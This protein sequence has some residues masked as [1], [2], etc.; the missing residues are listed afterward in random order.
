MRL[1]YSISKVRQ[2][3]DR[4]E[5]AG[6][7]I[8][9]SKMDYVP[10]DGGPQ[11]KSPRCQS[12]VSVAYGTVPARLSE[13]LASLG[14]GGGDLYMG[15]GGPPGTYGECNPATY[16]GSDGEV[17]GDD[18]RTSGAPPTRSVVPNMHD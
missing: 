15:S 12:V 18:Y 8:Y 1:S 2:R 3:W 14:G 11:P 6:T 10:L 9:L 7:E 16:A 17:C 13:L 5:A 4:L